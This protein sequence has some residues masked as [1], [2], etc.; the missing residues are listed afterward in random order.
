[1][2]ESAA[3]VPM[4]RRTVVRQFAKFCVVG[5][6]SFVID[7]G[8]RMVLL[9]GVPCGQTKLGNAFGGWLR[10]CLPAIFAYADKNVA[11]ALP[12]FATFSASVAILNSFF[13]NRSW[14]FRIRGREDAAAQLRRFVLISVIGL[15]LNVLF[16][17][18][19]DR[20]IPGPEKTRAGIATVL[21]AVLVAIW[22][23]V[24]QRLYAFRKRA[25]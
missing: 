24:G 5:V 2:D 19:F 18:A 1:M 22:N 23:F 4:W 25:R 6:A 13:W 12:V 7:Y 15:V 14:T 9:F 16:S 17:T 10:S 20:V 8:I 21:A 3:K 11:A